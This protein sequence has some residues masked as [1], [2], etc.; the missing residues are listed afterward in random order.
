[1]EELIKTNI[2]QVLR[3]DIVFSSFFELQSK[4][5]STIHILFVS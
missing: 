4:L 5:R 1:M 2:L 3:I